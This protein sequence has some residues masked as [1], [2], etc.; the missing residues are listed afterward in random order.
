MPLSAKDIFNKLTEWPHRGAGSEDEMMARETLMT[1]LTGEPG[2][3][4][5][6]EGLMAP[7]SYLPFFW[8][9][10]LGQAA[11]IILA[12]WVP[13][14]ALMA[15]A[16]FLGSHLSFFDWR[17]TPL[18]WLGPKKLTANLVAKKGAG[19]RLFILMAHLDSAPASFAYRKDQVRHFSASIYGGTAIV[20]LGVLVP[21]FDVL[22]QTAPQWLRYLLFL[23]VLAQPVVAGMDFWRFGCTPGAN[24]NLSGVAAATEAASRLWRHMPEDSEVR[25]VVT[26]AAEAGMLGAQH[27]WRAHQDELHARQTQVIN[28]DTLGNR[29]LKYVHLSGGFTQ[30]R[31]DGPLVTAAGNLS[32][33]NT[34]FAEISPGIHRVGDFDSVWFVRDNI[35]VLT[36]ASYDEEGLMPYIHTPE[37][38]RE[39]VD[40]D[41]VVLGARFGEALVRMLPLDR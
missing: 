16:V 2:V 22:G 5:A 13:Y 31:Y 4:V 26:T 7:A 37:D 8:M 14:I 30:I 29:K 3:E 41:N 19:R 23:V 15:G 32:R 34:A 38:T 20:G 25:L 28:F 12:M 18:V 1:V 27:Y 35:S 10:A 24:D 39:H 9:I 40:L 33:Q 36:L 17:V 21:L 6:E 11:A